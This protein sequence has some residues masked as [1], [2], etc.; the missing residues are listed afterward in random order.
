MGAKPL[1]DHTRH[2]LLQL[3][4]QTKSESLHTHTHTH[5]HT[6]LSVWNCWHAPPPA[7]STARWRV[8]SLQ[9]PHP[10]R[11][12]RRG[13]AAATVT[14]QEAAAG[15][16]RRWQT[17]DLQGGHTWTVS[18]RSLIGLS[19]YQIIYRLITGGRRILFSFV[20]RSSRW[21]ITLLGLTS[22]DWLG[23][24]KMFHCSVGK[25]LLCCLRFMSRCV[26]VLP[27]TLVTSLS[28]VKSSSRVGGWCWRGQLDT[29]AVSCSSNKI[30]TWIR[31]AGH[32]EQRQC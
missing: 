28:R 20:S 26:C 30:H 11:S 14:S 22:C 23:D 16:Q 3:S 17:P 6:H 4:H 15:W 32:T 18:D 24:Q 7:R 13:Y 19:R 27:G 8:W 5:T 31:P 1:E 21:G 2:F 25:K 12:G 29:A 9:P 10:S